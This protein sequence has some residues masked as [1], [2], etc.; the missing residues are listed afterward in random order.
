MKPEEAMEIASRVGLTSV[1][2]ASRDS[3]ANWRAKVI[4]FAKLVVAKNDPKIA[5]ADAYRAGVDS[6]IAAEREACARFS[7]TLPNPYKHCQISSHAYDMAIVDYSKAIRA[8]GE[9]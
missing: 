4:E 1:Y 5:I 6:G 7:Q 2:D 3:Y 8:R 9:A